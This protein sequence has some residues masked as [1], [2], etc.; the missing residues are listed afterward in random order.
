[1]M[2][3]VAPAHC[4]AGRIMMAKLHPSPAPL[5]GAGDVK[6]CFNRG[7]HMGQSLQTI[8]QGT[9][10]QAHIPQGRWVLASRCFLNWLVDERYSSNGAINRV[11][12][13]KFRNAMHY[14]QVIFR[15]A[16]T[17]AAQLPDIVRM[18]FWLLLA[19]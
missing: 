17:A 6:V 7:I 11:H 2:R 15:G 14:G 3:I 10:I 12:S 1:M 9:T 19:P 4:S 16:Q 5:F 13:P 8:G 18:P